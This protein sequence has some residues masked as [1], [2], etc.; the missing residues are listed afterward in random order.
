MGWWRINGHDGHINWSASSRNGSAI[1]FNCIP[2]RDDT[3]QLYNGDEPADILDAAIKSI[4]K[5]L[6]VTSYF[7]EAK[8]TFLGFATETNEVDE[9]TK[10]GLQQANEKIANVYMREWRRPPTPA[11]LSAIFEFCTS[12]CKT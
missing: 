8:A 7:N 1:L 2:G 5:N 9:S 4:E 3:T 6:H 11:E 12:F 10:T